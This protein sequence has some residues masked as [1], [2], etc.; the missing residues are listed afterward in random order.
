MEEVL[1]ILKLEVGIILIKYLEYFE[2]LS[3][4]IYFSISSQAKS[5][6]DKEKETKDQSPDTSSLPPSEKS[7]DS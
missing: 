3:D 7:S 6:E 2:E 1:K 5:K 4:N